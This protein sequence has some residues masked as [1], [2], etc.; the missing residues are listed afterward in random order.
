MPFLHPFPMRLAS[1]F[2]TS[3]CLI[4]SIPAGADEAVY[5]P[6][7][8][9]GVLTPPEPPAPR[10]NGPAVY[11]A[12]PGRP[13]LYRIPATGKEPLRFEAR[14]LPSGLKLDERT[15]V[16]TGAVAMPGGYAATLFVRNEA[17]EAKRSFRIEIGDGVALTPPMGWNSWNSWGGRVDAEKVLAT[18]KALVSSGLASHGWAYVNIDDTWQGLRSNGGPLRPNEKFPDMK[19]L[20]DEVHGLGLKLGIYSTPWNQSYAGYAGG[21]ADTSD[22]AWKR[23]PDGKRQGAHHFDEQDAAQWSAWGIDYLKYDWY[24]NDREA[25][26]RMGSALRGAARDIV[27]SLSNSAVFEHAGFYSSSANLWRTTGDIT[28]AWDLAEPKQNRQG[29]LNIWR[30]HVRWSSHN[31][32]GHWNDPDMLVV[33]LLG[34]GRELRPTRLTRDEQYSHFSLWCLWSAPLLLGCPIE[35]L[36]AFTLNLL[37]NDEVLEIDQD[38]LGA[39]AEEYAPNENVRIVFKK[40]SDGSRAIG[41]F[42]LG[43]SAAVV[44]ADWAR[45]GLR[46]RQSVRDAWRQRDLGPRSESFAAEVSPH[47]VVLVRVRPEGTAPTP[48]AGAV[49]P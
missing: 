14:G 18:A 8:S 6:G 15:G 38:A 4:A 31:G 32:P 47:G 12:R 33:G 19:A 45:V 48:E 39:Q 37:R 13:F 36:D 5:R 22:G 16:V 21:S 3:A 9:D 40:M 35:G 20:A 17:G 25:V 28:D 44:K 23:S 26:A 7:P 46:G 11:G 49:R 42:N 30:E 10:I 24:P 34:W 2:L 27:Y 41:L 29:I 43:E 1:L